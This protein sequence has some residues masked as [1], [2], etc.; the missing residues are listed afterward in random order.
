MRN[1]GIHAMPCQRSKKPVEAFRTIGS[2]GT[3]ASSGVLGRCGQNGCRIASAWTT[4]G[5]LLQ[6]ATSIRPVG[7]DPRREFGPALKYST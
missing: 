2:G 6:S 3:D 1:A 7:H 5:T 4:S